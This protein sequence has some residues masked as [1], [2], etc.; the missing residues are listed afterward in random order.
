MKAIMVMYDSLNRHL[1]ESYGCD[2]TKTPNFKRLAERA[3]QFE[4]SYVGSMPCMPARRDLHT[5]RPNFLHRSWGPLEPFD[6][7]MPEILKNNGI[8]SHL[9]SDHQ[10][11]WEDGG[12]TYHTRY[13]SWECIRGQ[14]GDPW[15]ENL[16]FVPD[17]RSVFKDADKGWGVP[18][19]A[20]L[21][22]HDQ[23][24]RSYMDTEEKTAQ[25]RTFEE[26]LEFIDTNHTADNWFLHIECFDPHEPFY[27]DEKYQKDFEGP[28][29]GEDALGIDWPPYAKVNESEEV[30]QT[31]RNRYAALLEKCDK[32]L[33]KVLDRMDEYDLWK[34]TM[35]IL[36]TDHGFLLGEHE[37][38]GKTAM[39]C[40]NEIAHTPMYVY[41]PR[42]DCAGK[43][44][45]A[46]V[47]MADLSA[48]VLE[49]FGLEIPK[50]MTGKP[51]RNIMEGGIKHEYVVFGFHGDEIIV[52][53]G[54]YLYMNAP[55][56]PEAPYYEYTLMPT[57]M[58]ARFSVKEL[59]NW[60]P[61][62]PFS[63]TKG[64]RTMKIQC[65]GSQVG[66]AKQP[67]PSRL[68]DLENDPGQLHEI[69]DPEAVKHMKQL[70]SEYMKETDAPK[71]LYY[72]YGIEE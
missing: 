68:Y 29:T 26:G 69:D 38:W 71:E 32:Y 67:R 18:M 44:C 36:C 24:N 43:K 39:P 48:T 23:V 31:V 11:Y 1:L 65:L 66:G 45:D 72:R 14:E 41:D 21:R 13:S 50:D 51:V 61:A 62:E 35:L 17:K 9:V 16:N 5:G 8:C 58:R 49:F 55:E 6:D 2:W 15:K 10:H 53:D 63:F 7:S 33:G 56:H 40:W 3:T 27:V 12:A 30:V 34:D 42:L 46:F 19:W 25:A 60:E 70:I 47:Q 37:W 22:T 59:E 64:L 54:K 4:N 28:L 57:H 52:T 20:V